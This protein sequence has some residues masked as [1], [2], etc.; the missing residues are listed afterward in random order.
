[1]IIGGKLWKVSQIILVFEWKTHQ[2]EVYTKQMKL[3]EVILAVS[4]AFWNN[5]WIYLGNI[6]KYFTESCSE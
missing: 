2:S 1:M 4:D 3:F 6:D 5:F